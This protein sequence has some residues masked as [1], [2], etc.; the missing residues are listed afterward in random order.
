MKKAIILLAAA[1]FFGN[2]YAAGEIGDDA[3]IVQN[4][5]IIVFKNDAFESD[6]SGVGA[7]SVDAGESVRQLAERLIDEADQN[8]SLIENQAA[9]SSQESTAPAIGNR[10]GFVYEH[11]LKGFSAILTPEAV[12]FLRER[13]LPEIDYIVPDIK[14]HINQSPTPSWGLDRID[15]RDLPLNDTYDYSE[16]GSGVHVYVIDTGILASHDE[17]IGRV[18]NGKDFAEGFYLFNQFIIQPDN[19]PSDCNGHGTHVA[20][21]ISGTTYGVAKDVTLHGVRVLDCSGSGFM[22]S[23]I[24]GVDWVTAH[25][26]SPAV[27]NM[28][29]GGGFYPPLDS[30]VT[31]S[32][33]R[34][35]TYVVAAGNDSKDA[36]LNSPARV[37][38]AITVAATTRYDEQSSF[39][40]YGD[41]V[42]IFAPGSDIVSAYHTG[43]T[44][45]TTMSGTSMASPHVAGVVA[46]YLG[47]DSDATPAEV[48]SAILGAASQDKIA[49]A[50]SDNLLLY[51]KY[52]LS[53]Y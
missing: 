21:T 16:M 39:S 44:A 33:V 50:K 23:V 14:V 53:G 29:L 43:N 24:R 46:L 52:L 51:S 1:F 17:F 5:Y 15:Q 22:S 3:D 42:D 37:P 13:N 34:G 45:T 12:R 19:D 48:T 36:C 47:E 4:Q 2:L 30:A 9:V 6:T 38:D 27:A 10:L 40:N 8:Q 11:A 49:D 7:Q 35:I 41:C 26:Q 25:H 18:G 31:N 32:V 20:G 28:S